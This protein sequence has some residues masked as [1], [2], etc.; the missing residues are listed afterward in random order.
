MILC[1]R[2]GAIKTGR[3]H[4]SGGAKLENAVA[5]AL[6]KR[7]NFLTDTRGIKSDL[8]YLRDRERREVDFLTVS[9]NVPELMIEVKSSDDTFSKSLRYFAERLKPV[10]AIQLVSK[11]SKPMTNKFGSIQNAATWLAG[12]EA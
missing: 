2:A 4:E 8:Y 1:R 9:D 6:L 5:C 10:T 7:A 12:L 11:L 3:V